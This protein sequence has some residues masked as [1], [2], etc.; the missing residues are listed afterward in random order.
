[1]WYEGSGTTDRRFLVTDN[2]GSVVAVTNSSGTSIATNTY[3]EY[4]IPG[5]SSPPQGQY[6]SV[7]GSS[8]QGRFQYTGQIW[9][10]ELALYHYKARVYSPTLGRFMQPDP[11][12]YG[13]GMNMYAYV[14]NDPANRVDPTGLLGDEVNVA[15]VEVIARR[16]GDFISGGIL[17]NIVIVPELQLRR[18]FLCILLASCE[19]RVRGSADQPGGGQGC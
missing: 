18:K 7:P 6:A 8:N 17:P 19:Q 11:I 9:I 3:D 10:P 15:E 1:M 5:T 2:Q 16:L 4:G 12:G 14:S 13:D